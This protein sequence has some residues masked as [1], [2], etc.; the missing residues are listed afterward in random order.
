MDWLSAD[1]N[2]AAMRNNPWLIALVLLAQ[3]SLAASADA[4]FGLTS[5]TPWTTS[6]FH[7][8]P[9]PPPPFRAERVYPDIQ[10]TGPTVLTGAPGTKRWF[11]AERLGKIY[12]FPVEGSKAKPDLFLDCTEL[13]KQLSEH[14]KQPI[15]F[16]ALYGLTFDPRFEQN[17][18]C[19]V[20]YVV[21]RRGGRPQ[22]PDGTRVVRLKV[23]DTN[24]PRCEVASE[25]TIITWLEGGHNG[26]CLKFGRDG[27]LYISTGDGGEAFPPDG[28]NTG[29]DLSDLLSS[30]L[31]IDVHPADSKR[32]Y[33]IPGD[34]PFVSLDKARGENWAY[35]L[36]NPWKMSFD[37]LTGE[38]WV[39]DV[40]WELWELIYRVRKG[41]NYGWSLVEGR[42]SVHTEG[43]PGPT[44]VI[45]PTIDI[46]HTDGASVTGGYV[47]RGRQFPELYGI[48][49]FGDWETRRIWGAKV[50]EQSVGQY[51]ELVEPTV[52][53]V[54]FAEDEQGE[55]YLLDNDAGTIHVLA[56]NEAKP[57][58]LQFP[59]KLSDTGIFDSVAE[60]RVAPGVLPFSINAEQWS[61]YAVAQRYLAL[62]EKTSIGLHSRAMLI[63]GKQGSRIMDFPAETVLTKTLSLDLIQ[64]DPASRR[65][66]E[67]QV[68]HFDGIDWRGYS[69]EWNEQQT[70]AVLVAAEGKSRTWHVE[71]AQ[72]PG[73]KRVQNWLFASRMDCIRCHNPWSEHT[74]AFNIAQLNRSHDFG[75]VTDNQIRTLKHIGV[76]VD[77][78]DPPDPKDPTA[79]DGGPKPPEQL[80]RLADL[81]DGSANLDLRARAY[82]HVNCSHCHRFNG[83]GSAHIYLQHDLP[84]TK[85][86]ALDL[87]PIQGTFGIRDARILASADPYRSV[88][89]FRLAKS[90]PGHMPHLG[91]K[92]VDHQ[93]VSLIHDWIASLPGKPAES[94]SAK[95]TQLANDTAAADRSA[96]IA[97]LLST[98][99]HALRLA[100]AVR[101]RK[102]AEPNRQLAIE[103]ALQQADLA[104]RDL[105]EPFVPEEQRTKRLGESIRP[106]EILAMTGDSSRGRQL[107]HESTVTQ[108]R[109][110]HR[111]EGKGGE[112]GP[113]LSAIGKKLDRSKLLD[114]ILQPSASIDPKYAGWLVE[115]KA[116]TVITGLMVEKTDAA[117]VIKDMQNKQHRL[118]TDEIEALFPQRKS[119][120][121]DLLLRD[122]TAA[123]VADL[124]AYLSSLK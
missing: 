2:N 22:D 27:Y 31:R 67:T 57:T 12:S 49:I 60:H 35:G 53:I 118:A 84:L 76:L 65:R 117:I 20:C 36:R 70:D 62:P 94:E 88:L 48:Y 120:M 97:E 89:L 8:Q 25:K 66:I 30:I 69:Y 72:A 56:R 7:G 81:R 87:R 110:C 15:E 38:L 9:E 123:Q 74:L 33:V 107:F 16:H 34:N 80:P 119:L 114:S 37:R 61:D 91:S 10:F 111:S 124:L 92:L 96:A 98:P 5:R 112:L 102:L 44:P 108:C 45:P 28:K 3:A 115:T 75:S 83:G 59:R 43:I 29:Q 17:R 13:A 63:P 21:H 93:G 122:F 26:G 85:I 79:Q 116:G 24:P 121:P 103:A 4:P 40:G 41:E 95:L 54:D 32:P 100:H 113:D 47:Y 90:G 99:G 11:V 50:E 78:T 73:G 82:L 42:Q 109:N 71:D 86:K 51:R 23:S 104:I 46:P 101:Q 105:F 58:H 64:G 52:R 19:Y 6:K 14:E 55:L 39:G 106:Q 77:V 18:F 1:A 68:L